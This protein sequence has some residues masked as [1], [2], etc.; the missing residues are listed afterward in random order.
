[1][2]FRIHRM[3]DQARENFRASAHTS[4]TAIVKAKDYEPAGEIES[5]SPYAAWVALRTTAQP[6]ETGDIL[7]DE[8]GALR[9]AKYVGFEAAQWW[10]AEPRT[11]PAPAGA[12]PAGVPGTG[13]AL[14]TVHS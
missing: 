3:K 13:T 14:P 1:M 9:I 11:V 2:L 12:E 8:S 4:G 6:L 10:V 5:S 7:E